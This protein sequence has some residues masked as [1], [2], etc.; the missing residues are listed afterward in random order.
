[1][2]T[3]T[4]AVGPA[5]LLEL[6]FNDG[7]SRGGARIGLRARALGLEADHLQQVSTPVPLVALTGTQ[8]ISPPQSSGVSPF[9]WSWVFTLSGLAD[10]KVDLVDRHH[11]LNLGG[12]GVV[13]GLDRLRHQPVIGGDNEARQYRCTL[14]PRARIAVKAAWPG[15]SRKVID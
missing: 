10:G 11:D 5:A 2:R 13:D 4:V 15:V 3:M 7:A 6:S 12:L 14:A 1:M 9:S 8:M